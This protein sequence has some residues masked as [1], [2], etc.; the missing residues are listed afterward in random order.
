MLER[1]KQEL[2]LVEKKFGKITI[3]DNLE[4]VIVEEYPVPPGWTKTSTGLMVLIPSGY[5]MTP[6]DNF[7]ADNDLKLVGDAQLTNADYN[8]PQIGRSWLRF[9]YHIEAGW[10]PHADLL[11]G[12]N[13]LTFLVHNVKN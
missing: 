10:N 6:P 9:S 7:Y 3:G 11:Q 5:P 13:L 2:G 4:W 12:H 8:V 1:R